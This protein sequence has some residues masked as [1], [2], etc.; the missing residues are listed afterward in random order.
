MIGKKNR[1]SIGNFSNLLIIYQLFI[2]IHQQI[3][4]LNQN[5]MAEL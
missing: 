3:I 2:G 4:F 5:K 1:C